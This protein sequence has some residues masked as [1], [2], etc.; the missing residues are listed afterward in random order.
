MLGKTAVVVE[1]YMIWLEQ[2]N[3]EDALEK[4]L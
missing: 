1:D 2:V 3:I 4:L